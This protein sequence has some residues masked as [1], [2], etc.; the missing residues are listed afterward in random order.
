MT[1]EVFVTQKFVWIFPKHLTE[2]LM[3]NPN[4]MQSNW[5]L[6]WGPVKSGPPLAPGTWFCGRAGWRLIGIIK[7]A[8]SIVLYFIIITSAPLKILDILRGCIPD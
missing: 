7:Q 3:A 4:K 6:L 8:T 5:Q 2:N 1:K